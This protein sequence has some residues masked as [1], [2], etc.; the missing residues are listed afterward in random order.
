MSAL[1][2]KSSIAA[3][4]GASKTQAAPAPLRVAGPAARAVMAKVSRV[5][6]GLLAASTHAPVH[7][8]PA[9]ARARRK[10]TD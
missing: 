8:L 7:F 6:L 5:R 3:K 1:A 4:T 2:Q 9:I 10:L